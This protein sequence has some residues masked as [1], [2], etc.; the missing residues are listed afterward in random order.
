MNNKE[1]LSYEKCIQ[2]TKDGYTPSD[3]ISP[4][5]TKE[6][7]SDIP[8]IVFDNYLYNNDDCWVVTQ[9]QWNEFYSN[10]KVNMKDIKKTVV[11]FLINNYKELDWKRDGDSFDIITTLNGFKIILS[12]DREG[13]YLQVLTLPINGCG[14][15]I[16]SKEDTDILTLYALVWD[17][18]IIK[19]QNSFWGNLYCELQNK[20][21][22][23][24]KEN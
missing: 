21:E 4:I 1:Y 5:W 19:E 15:T 7:D 14:H 3:D 20:I 16:D 11:D 10:K 9:E 23:G 6:W 2:I 13:T 17:S 8:H 24:E 12:S 18:L 22:H